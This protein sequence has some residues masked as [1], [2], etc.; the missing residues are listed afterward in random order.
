MRM[1]KRLREE[2]ARA[3]AEAVKRNGP[4]ATPFELWQTS[5]VSASSLR[6]LAL[7][8]AFGSMHLD[9]Q[10][11]LWE[12][13]ALHGKP[14]PLLDRV[15]MNRQDVPLPPIPPFDQVEKDY[16]RVGLSLKAH[17]LSFLRQML[18]RR[19]VITAAEAK[20]ERR[21][22]FGRRVAVAGLVLFRQ[23]P[24]TA[25][26]VIFMTLEDE[27]GRVD[28]I[29]RPSVSQ[30]YR[31]AAVYAK[32]V[33]AKGRVERQGRVVHVLPTEFTDIEHLVAALPSLSRDFR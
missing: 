19:G 23:R 32:L 4:F 21:S 22:P 25:K 1:V 13:Q 27:T 30:R 10:H 3:I 7:A 33:I 29:V 26:G 9:R 12:L 11:A 14:L 6:T 5:E 18:A 17:P 28:L 15:A 16:Q 2:D 8:D 31:G 24:G 20:D